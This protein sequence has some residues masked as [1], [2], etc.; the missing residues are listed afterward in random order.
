MYKV[1]FT[2]LCIIAGLHLTVA[3]W[4]MADYLAET[5]QKNLRIN[6]FR[7]QTGGKKI[8]IQVFQHCVHGLTKTCK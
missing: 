5:N 1:N 2:A 8:Q 3:A 4:E 7:F 6:M